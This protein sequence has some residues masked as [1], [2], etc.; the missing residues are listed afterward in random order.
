MK[1]IPVN[2][3]YSIHTGSFFPRDDF[4]SSIWQPWLKVRVRRAWHETPA[5]WKSFAVVAASIGRFGWN[6]LGAHP[7]SI[8]ERLKNVYV[9]NF[10]QQTIKYYKTERKV[11]K[12]INLI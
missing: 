2:L 4:S 12:N 5:R 9:E 3:F 8:Q 7:I 10:H 11:Y 6:C 1:F